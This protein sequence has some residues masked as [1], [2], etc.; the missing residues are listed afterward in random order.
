MAKEESRWILLQ[1]PEMT[2]E[3]SG[4]GCVLTLSPPAERY[5]KNHRRKRI[6]PHQKRYT[7]MDCQRTHTPL[8][9]Q[10]IL[11][12]EPHIL[13]VA[14]GLAWRTSQDADEMASVIRAGIIEAALKEEDFL[15]RPDAQIVTRGKW[16]ARNKLRRRRRSV[17]TENET[18]ES[19]AVTSGRINETAI[20]AS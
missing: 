4:G 10:R 3:K 19:L 11:D 2:A 14:R 16:A 18:L 12:L 7:Q 6:I 20:A 9:W 5:T 15:N 1:T 13:S 17:A 8:D